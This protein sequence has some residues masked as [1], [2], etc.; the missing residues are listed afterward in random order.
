MVD[1]PSEGVQLQQRLPAAPLALPL[2]AATLA[3]L[4]GAGGGEESR[5]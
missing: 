1:L 3:G 2:S 5:R 4:Q